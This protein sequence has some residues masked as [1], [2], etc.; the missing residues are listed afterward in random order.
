M[1]DLIYA[2]AN[3]YVRTENEGFDTAILSITDE[4]LF[5]VRVFLFIYLIISVQR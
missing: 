5:L 1:K 4:L 2:N 3:V